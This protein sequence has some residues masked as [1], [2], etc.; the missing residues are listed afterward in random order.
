MMLSIQNLRKSFPKKDGETV[1]I[2]NFSLDVDEGEFICVL[3]PS[4]CGKTTLLRIIA[5]LEDPTSGDI[6]L[7]GTPIL[8][9]GSDRGMV[10]QDFALF[11]WR[12]VRKN[13]EF[14]LEI[15]RVPPEKRKELSQRYIDLVGLKGFENYHPNQLSGGMKQRVGIA[16]ALANEPMLLLMDEP[17]GALDAQ[18][19]NLMQ[20]ELLRI[21]SETK[22]TVLFITHSVDEACY[23]ADKIVV[24]TTRPGMVKETFE[25]SWER[26]RDRVSVEFANLRKKILAELEREVVKAPVTDDRPELKF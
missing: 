25:V 16:R 20:K 6:L 12:T 23:L 17:F 13:V 22:K 19:R 15:K 26:P 18:T 10:F 1:A 21:W 14:G 24:M 2:E 11:P 9:P 5:G 4:G 8:G 3:G 7:N